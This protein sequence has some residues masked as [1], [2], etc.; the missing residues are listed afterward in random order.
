MEKSTPL[1]Q[2]LDLHEDKKRQKKTLKNA[3]IRINIGQVTCSFLTVFL[4]VKLWKKTCCL[5]KKLD[6]FVFCVAFCIE[7]YKLNRVHV[8]YF[9]EQIE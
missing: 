2:N 1:Q 6:S 5:L 4:H 3:V 7:T 8:C 9:I